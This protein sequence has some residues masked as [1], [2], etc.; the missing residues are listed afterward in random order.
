MEKNISDNESDTTT[1]K[2]GEKLIGMGKMG[3]RRCLLTMM[4]EGNYS[5]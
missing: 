3:L 1:T 4:V 5:M 2:I